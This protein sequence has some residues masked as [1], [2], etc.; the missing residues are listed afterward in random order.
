M[1][2]K[3]NLYVNPQLMLPDSSS[4]KEASRWEKSNLVIENLSNMWSTKYL[5]NELAPD[6]IVGKTYIIGFVGTKHGPVRLYQEGNGYE[7]LISKNNIHYRKFKYNG[8]LRLHFNSL[9]EGSGMTIKQIFITDQVPDIVIPNE[10]DVKA[11]NQAVYP[12]GG[13]YFKRCIRSKLKTSRFRP[14]KSGGGL[15]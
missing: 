5:K 9:V 2:V 4:E 14:V 10:K 6:L 1:L 13:G 8:V 3:Q 12:A 11:D 15:C 7:E